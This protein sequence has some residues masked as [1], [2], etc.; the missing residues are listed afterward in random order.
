[1]RQGTRVDGARPPASV[2]LG[3]FLCAFVLRLMPLALLGPER[4]E[5]HGY[6]Y[7]VEMAEHLLAGEGL[8]R[9]MPYGQGDHFAIRTPGYPL[10][11]A[12]LLATPGDLRGK[13]EV[14]GAA[15][16][17]ASALLSALIAARLFGRGAGL[18]AGLV[19][20]AWP[21][22]IVHDGQLQ[23]TALYSAL[24]LACVLAALALATSDGTRRGLL[25]ATL[26]GALSALAV[27]TR[28]TLLPAV[29]A[30]VACAAWRNG[31]SR[32]ARLML[33]G[34]ALGVLLVSLSPWMLRNARVIG[35]PVLTSDAGRSLWLGNNAR[36]FEVYPAQSIDRAEERA[37]AALSEEQ[38]LEVRSLAGRELAQD[39][40]FRT[41]ALRFIRE[42]PGAAI[43]GGLRKAWA[44]FSPWQNPHGSLPKQAIHLVAYGGLAAV[45]LVSSWRQRRRW[46]ELLP[47][48][49]PLPL[50]ALHS[51][52]FFGHSAYRAYGDALL[53]ILA[54]AVLA[55]LVASA[56]AE[57]W[58]AAAPALLAFVLALALRL[59][60]VGATGMLRAPEDPWARGYEVGAAARSI[61]EGR[62]VADPFG[63]ETGPSA[64]VSPLVP[65]LVA[66]PA[67]I[68]GPLSPEPWRALVLLSALSSAL[69]APA[70]LVMARRLAAERAGL[71]A[72]FAWAVHPVGILGIPWE[73][74]M[75]YALL[76]TLTLAALAAVETSLRAEDAGAAWR[77]ACW[78]GLV[79]GLS[80]LQEPLALP[81]LLAWAA[82]R[83]FSLRR[84]RALM[85][86]PALALAVAALPATPWVVRNARV[87]GVANLRSWAG[88]ELWFGAMAGPGEPPPIQLHPS[89]NLRE[90]QHLRDVGEAAYAREKALDAVRLVRERPARWV[91]ACALRY[92]AFW[93][94]LPSWWRSTASHPVAP[95]AVSGL[96]GAM[97]AALALV[98]LAGLALA[99]R[100]TP[101]V[102]WLALLFALYPVT[103][104]LSH[105][106]ARYRLPLEPAL[107]LCACL[108]AVALHGRWLRRAH[109]RP[110]DPRPSEDSA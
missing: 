52:I 70:L 99:W 63:E 39:A 42:H 11:V 45:A 59:S 61:A 58:R 15:C 82:F 72:A 80:L 93:W 32:A 110:H 55:P 69:I 88:P 74:T 28:V 44:V 50:L 23:D 62:G 49:I 5:E 64:A 85:L 14:F 20:A 3:L 26:L 91:T 37:W 34:V 24:L 109:G 106:E 38:R 56:R 97:H 83:T 54:S 87:V 90:R 102:R 33:A 95:A 31:G 4:R 40:W 107:L 101:F 79:A 71:L 68:F 25:L 19:V 66:V 17:A 75:V 12:A 8:Y 51:A 1:M 18:A 48:A 94:G 73:A 43:V 16:G 57:R 41:E 7:Y 105:V 92:G 30:L 65:Y 89:R 53:A 6:D 36:L 13:V 81:F 78:L 104:A 21:A 67:R 98:G 108:G 60:L 27:L 9:T 47:V 10:V 103:Y 76:L 86:V 100:S 2:L 46:R 77:S 96:R 35:A 29:L 22:F 84:R